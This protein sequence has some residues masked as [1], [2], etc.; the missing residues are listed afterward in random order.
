MSDLEKS[1]KKFHF[2]PRMNLIS[3]KRNKV[4]KTSLCTSLLWSMGCNV[5]FPPKWKE[6]SIK[7][8]VKFSVNGEQYSILRTKEQ[9]SIF[10]NSMM[11]VNVY[12]NISGGFSQKLAFLLG[13][14]TFLKPKSS[15]YYYPPF[16]GAMFL[17]AFI[18]SDKGW[19]E[20]YKSFND[21]D[22]YSKSEKKNLIEYFLGIKGDDFFLP[23]KE[24][25]TLEQQVDVSISRLSNISEVRESMFD[26]L[27]HVD[28]LEEKRHTNLDLLLEDRS[29]QLQTLN[30]AKSSRFELKKQI[31]II[32]KAESDLFEDYNFATNNIESNHILCPTCGTSH[33]NDIV[34][35]FSLLDEREELIEARHNLESDLLDIDRN[36]SSI[37]K[38]LERIN[39]DIAIEEQLAD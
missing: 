2:G 14:R 3:G 32:K 27:N 20:L 36:I 7:T 12:D 1:A 29:F 21:L 33:D 35:R 16:P 10:S 26:M 38:S 6:L 34:N 5:T 13:N 19:G 25:S 24:R 31:Q 28:N 11:N 22:A 4:G 15:K 30:S 18:H 8:V 9:I 39:L 23:R 37:S 17:P